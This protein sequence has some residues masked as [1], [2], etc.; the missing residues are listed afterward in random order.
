MEKY[1]IKYKETSRQEE[2]EF[3]SNNFLSEK[4]VV[5]EKIDD[6]KDL[7]LIHI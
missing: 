5:F 3:Y 2:L 7:S 6:A 4:R 1:N